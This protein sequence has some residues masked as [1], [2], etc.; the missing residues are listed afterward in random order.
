MSEPVEIYLS[1]PCLYTMSSNEGQIGI[2]PQSLGMTGPTDVSGRIS[3]FVPFYLSTPSSSYFHTLP[4]LFT[5]PHPPGLNLDVIFQQSFCEVPQGFMT[6]LWL[7][8]NFYV[9]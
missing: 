3:T 4:A 1:L 8:H 9:L 5:S 7:Y 2:F 6:V